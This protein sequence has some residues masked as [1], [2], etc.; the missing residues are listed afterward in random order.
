M[1]V[2]EVHCQMKLLFSNDAGLLETFEGFL[3]DDSLLKNGNDA[4]SAAG[5]SIQ[6]ETH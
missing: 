1:S 3:P 2:D 6:E 5:E 4:K